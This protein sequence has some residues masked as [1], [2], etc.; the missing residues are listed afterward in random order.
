MFEVMSESKRE[1]YRRVFVGYR[2]G[3]WDDFV[4]E[5]YE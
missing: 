2:V 5:R 3:L 4:F 1:Y